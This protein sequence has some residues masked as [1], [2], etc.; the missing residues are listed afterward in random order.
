MKIVILG[1]G[2][3]GFHIAKQLCFENEVILIDNDEN[4]CAKA[5]ELDIQTIYGNGANKKI[6][7]P[8]IEDAYFLIA[9][10]GSDEVNMLACMTAKLIQ[11]TELLKTMA[12]ISNPDYIENIVDEKD[13]GFPSENNDTENKKL[14]FIPRRHIISHEKIGIDVMICPELVLASEIADILTIPSAIDA[15]YFADGKAE[16]MEFII[17]SE[18]EFVNKQI[19]DITLP[20][21]CIISALF[22]N[23]NVIIPDGSD[24]VKENDHIVLIGKSES[25]NSIRETFGEVAGRKEKIMVIGA[26]IVG[27]YLAK[28]IKM[29][30]MD[31][32]IIEHDK[33]RCEYIAENFPSMLVLFGDGTDVNLLKEEE[34]QNMDTVLSIT[35]S[36]EKNLLCALLAKQLGAKKVIARADRLEYTPLFEMVGVDIAISPR[37]ATL[38]EVF[39]FIKGTE[40]VTTIENEKAELVEYIVKNK[41]KVKGKKINSIKFPKGALINLIIRGEIT[42]VPKG[43]HVIE[44]NDHIVVFSLPSVIKKVDALF[45]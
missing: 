33:K 19:K 31:I 3:T 30:N 24:V 27:F 45:K 42:I 12:I 9:V 16:M 38:N 40:A 43:E 44:E 35:N 8:A 10:T 11:G 22:R 41:S 6:L 29:R 37:K 26:G 14:N 39:K 25:M 13:I 32:K 5:N 28:L 34:V 21:C 23:G 20:N 17:K 4:A 1:A 36:D 15:E 2:E 7:E 18:N